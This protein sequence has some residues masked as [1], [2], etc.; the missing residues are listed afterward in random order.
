MDFPSDFSKDEEAAARPPLAGAWTNRARTASNY[1]SAHVS[2]KRQL[3][4]SNHR[5]D[6]KCLIQQE[7]I[8]N[9]ARAF[10]I[11][12]FLWDRERRGHARCPGCGEILACESDAM[13]FDCYE[14][15]LL[16]RG[17]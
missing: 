5:P 3:H 7:N 11:E 6:C 15:D 12:A 17:C 10:A 4:D 8:K 2:L 13:C 9:F 1:F 16:E 14:A